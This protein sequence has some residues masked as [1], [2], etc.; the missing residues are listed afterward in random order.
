MLKI[1]HGSDSKRFWTLRFRGITVISAYVKWH[2]LY[3]DLTGVTI[4]GDFQIQWKHGACRALEIGVPLGWRVTIGKIDTEWGGLKWARLFRQRNNWWH[5]G[6][7]VA[8]HLP[9]LRAIP[10]M[11][12]LSE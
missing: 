5:R 7:G 12:E 10:P 3:E 4:G 6:Y 1:E 11:P 2:C 8:L 9:W